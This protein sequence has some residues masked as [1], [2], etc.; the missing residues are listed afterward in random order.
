MKTSIS[1]YTD[2]QVITEFTT[3]NTQSYFLKQCHKKRKSECYVIDRGYES[4]KM[5]RFI[6]ET[7]KVASIILARCLK[8]TNNVWGKY[9]KVMTDNFDFIR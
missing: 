3:Q 4:E 5:H 2:L 8:D 7:V 9:R 6:R 1:I